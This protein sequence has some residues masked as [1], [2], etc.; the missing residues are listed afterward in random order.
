MINKI[1]SPILNDVNLGVSED[2]AAV[3]SISNS[4]SEIETSFPSTSEYTSPYSPLIDDLLSSEIYSGENDFYSLLD[5]E[6]FDKVDTIEEESGVKTKT[7]TAQSL[8][9]FDLLSP[10][11]AVAYSMS[12]DNHYSQD[13]ACFEVTKLG[14][15]L[16]FEP[17]LSPIISHKIILA[18]TDKLTRSNHYKM[19]YIDG[20]DEVNLVSQAALKIQEIKNVKSIP[21]K[22][23]A[24]TEQWDVI[25]G[26]FKKSGLATE[27]FCAKHNLNIHSFRWF[28]KSRGTGQNN[29]EKREN[30][31]TA[32]FHK[33]NEQLASGVTTN[34]GLFCREHKIKYHVFKYFCLNFNKAEVKR[35][36]L[37]DKWMR[38]FQKHKESGL[39]IRQYCALNKVSITSF[40]V[41]KKR[42][43][44]KE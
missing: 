41:M 24:L 29:K 8:P 16:V 20:K 10:V 11:S 21:N 9:D 2:V 4:S 31:L 28:I 14:I 36:K 26:E 25:Y 32:L 23:D 22:R 42:F 27:T 30:I 34:M 18:F 37:K 6:V 17:P 3:A 40:G 7:V 38:I 19:E 1:S 44:F 33:Y 15:K 39:S 35:D 43:N 5:L 12:T 13:A